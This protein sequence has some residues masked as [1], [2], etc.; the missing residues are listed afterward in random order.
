MSEEQLRAQFEE[1]RGQHT[2][3]E[4]TWIEIGIEWASYIKDAE[5]ERMR[6]QFID[7]VILIDGHT[8]ALHNKEVTEL[9]AQA[10]KMR[11]ALRTLLNDTQHK[12]HNCGD[13]EYCSVLLARSVLESTPQ[14]CLTDHDR[15]VEINLLD[16]IIKIENEFG[17]CGVLNLNDGLRDKS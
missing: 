5:I 17:W 14:S 10:E 9:K 11:E 4:W 8:K 16:R 3:T 1:E 2:D 6:L 12:E 13:M 15:K 7:T